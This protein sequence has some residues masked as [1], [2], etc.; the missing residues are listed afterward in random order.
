MALVLR[1]K[2]REVWRSEVVNGELWLRDVSGVVGCRR[3][4]LSKLPNREAVSVRV[5]Y[6]IV[7][8]LS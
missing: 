2:T 1:L 5:Q 6:S 4:T 7:S 8:A 3:R